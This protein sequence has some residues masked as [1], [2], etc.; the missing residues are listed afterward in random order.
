MIGLVNTTWIP[1]FTSLYL[2]L[3][4][5]RMKWEYTN[6]WSFNRTPNIENHDKVERPCTVTENLQTIAGDHKCHDSRC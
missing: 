1:E 2:P 5:H 4:V 6:K 3:S